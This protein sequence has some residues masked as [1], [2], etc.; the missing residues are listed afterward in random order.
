M[1]ANQTFISLKEMREFYKEECKFEEKNFSEKEF[2]AF[3]DCCERDFHQWLSDN[4]K[5]FKT[6]DRPTATKNITE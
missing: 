6:E 4:L 5:Y 2:E 3:V 1:K